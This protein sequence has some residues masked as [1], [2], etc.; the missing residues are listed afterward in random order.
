MRHFGIM[1][2]AVTMT[3]VLAAG[4]AAAEKFTRVGSAR[5]FKGRVVNKVL[6]TPVSMFIIRGDG[7]LAGQVTKGPM[8]GSITGKWKW[9]NGSFCR[10][11]FLNGKRVDNKCQAILISRDKVMFVDKKGAGNGTLF[12]MK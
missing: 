8:A 5:T 12:S 1:F 6:E 2:V 4:D 10:T 11:I 7:T 3:I 9:K